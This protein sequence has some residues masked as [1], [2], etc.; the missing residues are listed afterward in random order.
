[1][2]KILQ[3]AIDKLSELPDNIQEELAIEIIE[4]IEWNKVNY[5]TFSNNFA[6]IIDKAKQEHKNGK[7]HKMGFDE[8]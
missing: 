3:T 6:K 7:T 8:I 5:S 4:E 1:M 2:K